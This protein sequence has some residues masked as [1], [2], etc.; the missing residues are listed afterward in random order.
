MSSRTKLFRQPSKG[1]SRVQ[2]FTHDPCRA[3]VVRRANNLGS[4]P[5]Y[6]G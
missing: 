2:L 6:R 1:L 3:F 4:P 5:K